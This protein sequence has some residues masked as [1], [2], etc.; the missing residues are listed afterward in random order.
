LIIRF[1]NSQ[2]GQMFVSSAVFFEG[3]EKEKRRDLG[4]LENLKSRDVNSIS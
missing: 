3:K 2:L 4:D 1:E